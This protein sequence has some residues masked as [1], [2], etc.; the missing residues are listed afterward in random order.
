MGPARRVQASPGRHREDTEGAVDRVAP[1][2]ELYAA[3]LCGS[4]IAQ[5]LPCVRDTDGGPSATADAPLIDDL[6]AERDRIDRMI[7]DL[8]R[9]RT[10]LDEVIDAAAAPAAHGPE[11]PARGR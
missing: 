2:Q 1:I 6:T 10:A 11:Q 5:L 4:K 3:G 7:D 8:Q 9:S